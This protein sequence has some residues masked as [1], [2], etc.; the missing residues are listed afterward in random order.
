MTERAEGDATV[1]DRFAEGEMALLQ[2]MRVV[3]VERLR[4]DEDGWM[5][6]LYRVR[7]AD[8]GGV[9]TTALDTELEQ[10]DD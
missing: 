7:L 10:A 2:G 9:T 6:Q 4:D 5:H 3:V 1:I 8:R